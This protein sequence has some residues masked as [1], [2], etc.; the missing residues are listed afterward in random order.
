MTVRG[1]MDGNSLFDESQEQPQIKAET[2]AK[3]FW[4]WSKVIMPSQKRRGGKIAYIDLFAGPGR[5]RDGTTSTPILILE[6]AIR[7]PD[8]RDMLVT[9]FNDEDSSSTQAP[10]QAI[11]SIPNIASL[12]HS[13]DLRNAE[14]GKEFVKMFEQKRLVPT[15]FLVDPWGY[16]GLSLR[17]ID[18]VGRLQRRRSVS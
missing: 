8:M 1:S 11:A 18:S 4:A 6:Q 14:V 7:D 16:K 15:L 10:G 3:R 2:A 17:L 13:P 12:R 5:Y 9:L